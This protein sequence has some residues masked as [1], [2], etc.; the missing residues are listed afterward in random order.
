M[1]NFYFLNNMQAALQFFFV[2]LISKERKKTE[3][4]DGMRVPLNVKTTT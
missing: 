2:L 4:A 1:E 3:A